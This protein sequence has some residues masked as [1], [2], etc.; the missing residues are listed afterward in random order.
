MTAK[1]IFNP[2]AGRWKAQH[3][4]AQAEAAL[5]ANQIAY[6]LVLTNGPGHATQLAIQA[7]RDGFHPI[8]AAGGDGTINEVVNGLWQA[9]SDTSPL[10]PLG[11]LPIGSANDL[12]NNLGLPIDLSAAAQLLAA[13]HTHRIDLGKLTFGQPPRQHCFDNNA[14]I[15]LE[16]ATTLIQARMR[17]LQG[18]LRYLVAALR[19]IYAGLHWTAH[20]QWEGGEYRGPISLV[21]I[22]NGAVT[23]GLFYMAPHANPADGLFTFVYGY[24]ASRL[25]LLRLL[26]ATMKPGKGSYVEHPGI[27][28]IHSPWLRI[29]TDTPAPLHADGEIQS[30]GV[31][32]TE[33]RIL[34]GQ[35]EIIGK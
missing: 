7:S 32:D 31:Q 13:G 33:F 2:Y 34:P 17:H 21:T 24:V 20:L 8:I 3:L 35:L 15:G 12:A 29:H 1:V 30:E 9:S 11:V 5:Q 4:R 6:E 14:A 23:G 22:G 25:E 16:P 18:T 27:H 10:G 26:P 28:E 19:A